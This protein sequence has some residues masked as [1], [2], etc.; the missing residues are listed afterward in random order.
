MA[1][2]SSLQLSVPASNVTLIAATGLTSATSNNFNVTLAIETLALWTFET[3]VP[4]TAG[5]HTAE[6][7][8]NGG[9]ATNPHSSGGV[10]YSNFVGNG[11]AESFSSD[12]WS[13]G[14]YYQFTTSTS[15]YED[16]FLT[17][18]Q[19]SS[20]SGPKNFKVQYSTDGSSFTD[21]SGGSYVLTNDSWS[22]SGSPKTESI[23]SF[24]LSSVSSLDNK[25]SIYIRLTQVGTTSVDGGSVA[26]GGTN[27]VDNVTITGYPMTYTWTGSGGDNKW[28]TT[29]NWDCNCGK[30]PS[31][32][33]VVIIPNGSNVILDTNYTAKLLTLQATSTLKIAPLKTLTVAGIVNFN[34]Q[35][36]TIQS[37][38]TGTGSIGKITGSL[39]DATNVTVERYISASGNRA[40]RLLAPSVNTSTSIK[41]NWMEG[42]NN[43]DVSTNSSPNAGYGTHITGAL[44]ATNGFDPTQYNQASLLTLSSGAWVAA[45]N[46]SGTLDAKTGYLLFV[47]GNRD[48]IN[49]INTTTG[50]SNTTLRA[51]GTLLTGTQT[52]S[53]LP[54]SSFSLVTNPY[55]SAIDWGSIYTANSSNFENFVTIW[56]P[57]IG[58]RGGYVSIQNDGTKSVASVL[59]KS[60]QS[61]QAFFVKTK[62][63]GTKTL[64]ITEN[65]K[66]SGNNNLDAYRSGNI[67]EQ[68]SIM[69]QFTANSKNILADGAVAKFAN[70]YQNIVDENDAT[71]IS[72]FDE[73][74]SLMREEKKLSIE[75]RSSITTADTLFIGI[76]SLKP[77]QANYRWVI[78]PE[79]FASIKLQAHLQ[80]NY[81]NTSKPISLSDTTI[82][83]FS[84]NNDDASKAIDRF[85]IVFSER[86]TYYSKANNLSANDLNSWSATKDG[87]G[88][89]PASF[90]NNALFV[91]QQGH[92][93]NLNSSLNLSQSNLQ[94]E[95]NAGINNTGNL[96][97]G[98]D[99]ENNG[100]IIGTGITEING[101][102]KQTISGVGKISNLKLNNTLGANIDVESKVFVL[103][104]YIP[105]AG[106]L[107]TNGNLV[108]VSNETST[109]RITTGAASGNYLRGN[110]I[111]ERFISAKATR[112]WSFITSPVTQSIANSWQ[113]Q[114]HITGSGNGGSVCPTPTPHTNGFDA[115]VTNAPSIYTYDASK[116]SGQRWIALSNTILENVTAG[117]AFRVNIRGD[118]NL[119]CSLLDGSVQNV[120][121]VLL[122]SSGLVNIES[123]N[124][125][126]FGITYSNTTANN[127][128]F[129]GNPY[130]SAIS[131][132]A[133]QTTNAANI[134]NNYAIY[135]PT[136]NA[137]IYTYWDGTSQSFTG[138]NGYDDLTGN[139]IV[140]G[141]AFFVQSIHASNLTLQF[142]EDQKTS[143]TNT[144][145]FKPQT[146]NEKIKISYLQ[147][148]SKVDEAII[149]FVDDENISNTAINSLDIPSMNTGT[150]ISSK[151]GNKGLVIQTRNANNINNEEVWLNVEATTS[152]V[153]Q[154]QFSEFENFANTAIY[155]TDHYT[156]TTQNIQQNTQYEFS[157]DKNV[158][159]TKG[160]N[161]FS[162]TFNRKIQPTYVSNII[163]LYP[164]PAN[165]Q[166]TIELPQTADNTIT[167]QI[168]VTDIAGKI[169]MEQK[170][171]SGTHQLSLDK[172]TTGTYLIEITD[173]K[174]N[175]TTEKLVK[176]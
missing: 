125:G 95:Q 153:Y 103:E 48:N 72:N 149:R 100:S 131:F 108:L 61:G 51:T 152:G 81:T 88:I 56:D 120:S 89:S 52:F 9:N 105:T 26:T 117:K 162:I 75:S 21:L 57:N 130:P 157:I 10:T 128:V 18:H 169:V 30:A 34:N 16:I 154:L 145:Y 127:Y 53:S 17:I 161:R 1:T 144:G 106:I 176:Q 79:N 156:N 23:Y 141:Q 107:N 165:K 55:A 133:L 63:G 123:K 58:T 155:L 113:Q 135:I 147:N 114:I 170:Q 102:T 13:D 19:T 59:T 60:I 96:Y 66:D 22:S 28:T 83:A 134:A 29:S 151:K 77:A 40:Y 12:K 146:I 67:A 99:I 136:N 8:I 122:Q 150:F 45:S 173:T 129:V 132:N 49:T 139:E 164:N 85:R 68:L 39:N 124:A 74:I 111:V 5:P 97:L 71:Q 73:D 38:A 160:S 101:T 70:N 20:S 32:N 163:K 35:S 115:T 78:A 174:G 158:A 25:A 91:I 3:S 140:S 98:N 109:A 6:G 31:S 138:G 43:T 11:S 76:Q 116:N 15:G 84:V 126:N 87:T 41:A 44:G 92:V 119:G 24:D 112:K 80:D 167:Y 42:V 137:G 168:K 46:T 7:G 90:D 27:R 69:L 54:A 37:N 143:T 172:L 118:R 36:V 148:N 47:R 2:F 104:S 93:L 86:Q 50:S 33:H 175:K 171:L 142:T 62:T 82:I 166:V 64:T 4:T 110:V 14:D 65:N 94:I 159:A 121:S